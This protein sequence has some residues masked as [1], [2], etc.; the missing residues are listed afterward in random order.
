MFIS[1][2]TNRRWADTLS[3]YIQWYKPHSLPSRGQLFS[4]HSARRARCQLG[5][6]LTGSKCHCLYLVIKTS[7]GYFSLWLQ[8]SY[9]HLNMHLTQFLFHVC[10]LWCDY[11][12]TKS[13]KLDLIHTNFNK[14]YTCIHSTKLCSSPEF[15][16]NCSIMMWCIH[17]YLWY[18]CSSDMDH[19]A[20]N[21]MG[22]YLMN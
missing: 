6:R 22:S 10:W 9:A 20:G 12:H 21:F 1:S 17:I 4:Q 14:G 18:G 2:P 16:T 7:S 15:S 13:G 11:I 3:L 19:M 5:G 8:S